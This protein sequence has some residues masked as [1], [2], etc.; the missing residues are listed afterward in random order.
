MPRVAAT[1]LPAGAPTWQCSGEGYMS[2]SSSLHQDGSLFGF[3]TTSLLSHRGS[4]FLNIIEVAA[5]A[6]SPLLAWCRQQ[7]VGECSH[8]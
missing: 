5:A 4:R 2:K 8:P 3:P 7:A 6:L 1:A